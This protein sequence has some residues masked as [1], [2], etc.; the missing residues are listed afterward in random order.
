MVQRYPVTAAVMEGAVMQVNEHVGQVK[1]GT[2]PPDVD[3]AFND[4]REKLETRPD[5][6][7]PDE[8]RRTA[9]PTRMPRHYGAGF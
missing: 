5:R 3:R 2:R 8:S 7:G 6:R 9:E 1:Q 4:T